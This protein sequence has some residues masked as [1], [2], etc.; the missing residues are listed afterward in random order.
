VPH[1]NANA[2]GHLSDCYKDIGLPIY[3]E[4]AHPD[5]ARSGDLGAQTREIA[6]KHNA[7]QMSVIDASFHQVRHGTTRLWKARR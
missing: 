6:G 7:E 2:I 4:T 1:V 5:C 3:R